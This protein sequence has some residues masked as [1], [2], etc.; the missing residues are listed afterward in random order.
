MTADAGDTARKAARTAAAP[1]ERRLWRLLGVAVVV[2]L[3]LLGG[4]QTWG[5]VVQQRTVSTNTYV[6]PVGRVE[7]DTGSAAVRIT[8]GQ[9]DRVTVRQNLDWLVRK[10]MI[11]VT[12]QGPVLTV[13]AR[14]PRVLP[15]LGLGCGALIELEVPAATAVSGANTSGSVHVEGLS[16]DVRLETT[17][18]SVKLVGVSGEVSARTTSGLV[19]GSDLR[20]QRAEASSTSGAV[21]LGFAGPPRAVDVGTTSGRIALSVPRGERYAISGQQGSGGWRIDPALGDATSSRSI[22]VRTTSG[23]VVIEPPGR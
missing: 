8:A 10:P 5:T 17:S 6:V 7:L 4:V 16:G 1:R 3:V 21:E 12:W 2:P 20:S 23:A 13:R 9:G 11:D 22:R 14:C 15:V 18:G 19:Q